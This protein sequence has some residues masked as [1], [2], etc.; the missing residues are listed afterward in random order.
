MLEHKVLLFL[1]KPGEIDRNIAGLIANK[2]MAKYQ[3]PV[4]ILTKVTDNE[5]GHVSYQG[6]ARGYGAD[7]MF[8]DI[9]AEAGALFAE[10][11]QGAFG[12]GLDGGYPNDE[13]QAEV[14][15][16]G[17]Y[18]FIE[19]TDEILKD[20]SGEPTYFSINFHSTRKIL[21]VC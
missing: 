8:K 5:T 19:Q 21:P 3:R 10:G 6:S 13:N 4:C 15:G 16:E 20:M 12:L 1:L 14:A 17:L 2:F 7:M 11:H 9:C 18:Q